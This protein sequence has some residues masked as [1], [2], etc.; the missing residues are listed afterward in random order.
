ME[1]KLMKS[2]NIYIAILLALTYASAQAV[3]E[4]SVKS[5]LPEMTDLSVLTQRPSP[6]YTMAQASS[7]DRASKGPDKPDWFANGDAGQFIRVENNNGHNEYVML[8]A[9]GP[10]TVVRFWSANPGGIVRFYFDG[11]TTAGWECKTDDLLGGR[12]APFTNPFAY[13]AS[14]GWN[15]YFPIPYAKSLKITVDQGGRNMYYHVGYRTYEPGTVVKTF[16]LEQV[17]A[18]KSLMER[19]GKQLIGT[20]WDRPAKIHVSSSKAKTIEPGSEQSIQSFQLSGFGIQIESMQIRVE[21]P[22]P[23]DNSSVTTWADPAA[24]QNLLRSLILKITFDGERC[25]EAPLGDFFGS[26]PGLN[27]YQS[28]PMRVEKDGTL[29][30]RFPMPVKRN[31]EILIQNVG[32]VPARI[33]SV[34]AISPRKFDANTYHFHAQWTAERGSTRPMRDMTFLDVEGEGAFVGVN[35][36][37]A[38]PNPAWWGEGDEKVYVNG[39]AFPSTF[40]TGT[41]DYFGYAWCSPALFARPYHAQPRCD[42]PANF[43]HTSVIRWQLFDPIPYTNSLK[44]DMELWHWAE[45]N[46]TYARTAYWYAKP[47]GTAPVQV[48]T[49]LLAPPRLS[50]LNKVEG[51]LEGETLAFAKTGGNTEIQKGFVEASNNAQLWWNN[52][53]VGDYLTVIVPVAQD[54]EYEVVLGHCVAGDYGKQAIQLLGG[55]DDARVTELDSYAPKLTFKTVSLGQYTLKKGYVQLKVKNT[56]KNAVAAPGMHFGLDYVLLKAVK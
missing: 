14:A 25:V 55:S 51:A 38:N 34:M 48:D 16:S 27:I 28:Y 17:A 33:S 50:A 3:K 36:H 8:D 30:C 41:E 39:E 19:V 43:G 26:A 12:I 23:E 47:G 46:V 40:G 54:G 4:V 18:E 13:V 2:R 24:Y 56:G 42:G 21:N 9:K 15:L 5:L 22:H 29:T 10:G 44:F 7:Y 32:S 45:V 20:D 31:A 53:S 37:I 11:S 52:P 35:A 1:L 49:T 6:N